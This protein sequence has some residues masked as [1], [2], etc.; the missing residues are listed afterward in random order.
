[1][2]W[3]GKLKAGFKLVSKMSIIKYCLC[4]FSILC[5]LL[6]ASD[7]H[8][9]TS[10]FGPKFARFSIDVPANWTVKDL[11]NGCQLTANNG[12]T[13]LAIQI[14]KMTADSLSD[15]VKKLAKKF[16]SHFQEVTVSKDQD[17]F[18]IIEYKSGNVQAKTILENEDDNIIIISQSGVDVKTVEKII[19]SLDDAE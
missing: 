17:N 12:K 5:C 18:F 10:V 11:G 2:K 16:K 4:M 6:I 8:A 9:K 3:S 14:Q 13:A 15:L 1:M 19:D 7:I